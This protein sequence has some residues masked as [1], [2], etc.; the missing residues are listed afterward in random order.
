MGLSG[1][2][3]DAEMFIDFQSFLYPPTIFRY[4]FT[5]SQLKTFH[6]PRINFDPSGYEKNLVFATA[7]DGTQ[8]PIFLTHKQG[9]KRDGSQPT[10]LYGYGGFT[11]NMTPVP[12][13]SRPCK[14]SSKLTP[15]PLPTSLNK[16]SSKSK[17]ASKSRAVLLPPCV[18]RRWKNWA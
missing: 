9:L 13:N 17:R 11:V 16:P 7:K 2:R 10:L 14:P 18:L 12:F 5:T 3:Q 8:V 4:D 15:K 6:Q 1:K